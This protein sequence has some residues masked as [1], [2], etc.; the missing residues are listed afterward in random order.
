[1]REGCMKHGLRD[2]GQQSFGEAFVQQSDCSK[3][4][5]LRTYVLLS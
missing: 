3:E 4:E 2:K 5:V 1:M